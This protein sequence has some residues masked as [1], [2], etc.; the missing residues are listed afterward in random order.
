MRITEGGKGAV[1][2]LKSTWIPPINDHIFNECKV[3]VSD[4]PQFRL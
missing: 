1:N 3:H 4:C 2:K